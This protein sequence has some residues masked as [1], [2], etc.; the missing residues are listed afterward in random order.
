MNI[1]FYTNIMCYEDKLHRLIYIT[2]WC[3]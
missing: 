2:G 3:C 1:Y